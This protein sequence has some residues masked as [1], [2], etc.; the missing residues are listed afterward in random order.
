MLKAGDLVFL[1]KKKL[2][3][4][5]IK[6][7]PLLIIEEGEPNAAYLEGKIRLLFPRGGKVW[8]PRWFVEKV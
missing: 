2:A 6:N 3:E 4:F 7:E 1:T 5:G 8:V